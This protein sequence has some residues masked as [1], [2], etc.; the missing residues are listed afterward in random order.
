LTLRLIVP[1]ANQ[2]GGT[3]AGA[4]FLPTLSP[5]QKPMLIPQKPIALFCLG[6][7]IF[8]HSGVFFMAHELRISFRGQKISCFRNGSQRGRQRGDEFAD[9]N[10]AIDG[11]ARPPAHPDGADPAPAPAGDDHFRPRPA[12]DN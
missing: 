6:S 2:T 1:L 11:H 3:T 12:G 5:Y 9:G 7:L 8:F 10:D 4:Q